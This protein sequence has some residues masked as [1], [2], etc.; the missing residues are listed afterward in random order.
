MMKFWCSCYFMVDGLPAI[1]RD[2][3]AEG[4]GLSKTP[5]VSKGVKHTSYKNHML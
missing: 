5:E 3:N 4:N 2:K 1:C